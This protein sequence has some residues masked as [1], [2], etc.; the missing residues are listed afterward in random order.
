M[1][2]LKTK[3]DTIL[4]PL[5][6]I[7][8]IVERRSSL[9]L[10]SNVLVKVG[11]DHLL[12][13]TSDIEIEMKSSI[14]IEILTEETAF[15]VAAKKTVDI[16]K[17]MSAQTEVS[18][19]MKSNRLIIAQGKS[20]YSLQITSDKDF[21][22][23]PL[24]ENY[25]ITIKER[26]TSIR[27][28]LNSISFSMAIQDVRYYLNGM[29]IEYEKEERKINAVATDGHRLAIN[30]LQNVDHEK[31]DIK[32]KIDFVIPRKAV[33]EIEKLC[34]NND[35]EVEITLYDQHLKVELDNLILVTKL[36]DG[37]YPN[38]QKV[39]P[40]ND[41]NTIQVDR[42]DLLGGLQRV[43]VLTAEKYKGIKFQVKNNSIILSSSNA[44]QEEA[45][46]Q[47]DCSETG[48]DLSIGFNVSYLIEALANIKS[49][50]IEMLISD[51]QSS[52]VILDP[53]KKD[54]KYIVMPMRI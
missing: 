18:L 26:Q 50:D 25:I 23:I 32:E 33:L 14:E 3:R 28:L 45:E 6:S 46:E 4:K 5:Q 53:E 35:N 44:E 49:K 8:N 7:I 48:L 51:P 30:N 47:I 34:A 22:T 19:S 31:Q 42:L 43:S 17:N 38:Y 27:E 40:Q 9:P 41:Q 54:F 36:I 20:K 16:L 29:Y 1:I 10:L 24:P 21:P 11:K 37:K 2:L 52:A 13:T 12:F 39:M 15:T